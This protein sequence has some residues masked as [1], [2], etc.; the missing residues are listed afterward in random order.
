MSDPAQELRD[1]KKEKDFLIGI[2]SDGCAFDTMEIKHKECFTPNIINEW[3][4]Q[5]VSKYAREASEFVNLYSKWRGINRFPALI[6]V[7]DL[8]SE[9]EEVKKR[10]VEMPKVDS[11]RKWIEK[12]TKLGNPALEKIVKETNDPVLARTL[13]WSKEVNNTVAKF[14]RGVPPFPFVRESLEAMSKIADILVVSA[15]PGE[16]LVRE[17]KEHGIDKYVKVIAGQEMGTKKEHLA[18]ATEGRYDKDKVLMIGDANGDMKAAHANNVH[19]YPINPGNE[20]ASWEKLLKESL[21]KFTEGKYAGKYE[22]KL[23]AEFNTYLPE[24][25]P[26]KLK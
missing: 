5:A 7:F 19:F 23:I 21:K 2:D 14:V 3:D 20:D 16:A 11:L 8:L 1:F 22:E 9:R 15:T 24:T 6:M 12:E 10:G 13:K 17:W 25:P 18:I 4:L 26:W